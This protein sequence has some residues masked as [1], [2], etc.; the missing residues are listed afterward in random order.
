[1]TDEGD[2]KFPRP[3]TDLGSRRHRRRNAGRNHASVAD[4]GV[5]ATVGPWL[6][7]VERANGDLKPR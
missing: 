5:A 3:E 2:G 7:N 6:I 1:M 4:T